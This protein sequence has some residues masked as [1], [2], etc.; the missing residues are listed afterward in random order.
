MSFSSY[1]LVVGFYENIVLKFQENI[2]MK[3]KKTQTYK[4]I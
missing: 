2:S 4:N 3:W 1:L